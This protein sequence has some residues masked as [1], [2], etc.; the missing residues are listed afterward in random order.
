M[1]I[2]IPENDIAFFRVTGNYTVHLTGNYVVSD[3]ADD[4]ED[5]EDD[6]DYDLSPSEDELDFDSD[7]ESDD[8]DDLA[9][10]RITEIDSEE[11]EKE[12]EKAKPKKE[13][14]EEPKKEKASPVAGKKRPA[15]DEEKKD[16]PKLSKKQQKKLKANDGKAAEAPATSPGKDAK[17]VKFAAQLEQGP[18]PSKEQPKASNVK[19]VNGIT[20][21]DVKVGSGPA[22]KKGSKLKMRYIGK[23]KNGNKFD[24]NTSGKPFSFTLGRGEVI[25]GW[26]IGLLGI[27]AGGERRLVIPAES[28][29]G[30]QKMPG[31]PPN[32]T[33][34]FEGK[35]SPH[36]HLH[37]ALQF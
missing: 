4:D 3:H 10:P 18:T 29:Y 9:D 37:F 32:S 30:S 26:D 35:H 19:K 20:I 1:N 11:E 14:K 15:E 21:E 12:K 22:A 31:I 23:L 13:K 8:L 7:E 25:K 24:S 6:E 2:T 17:K 34:I 5:S 33:L 16:E 36:P 27:Q 28:A